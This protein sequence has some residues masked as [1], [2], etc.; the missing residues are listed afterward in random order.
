MHHQNKLV[1]F[2]I[3]QHNALHLSRPL[4]EAPHMR[5]NASP[6]GHG[7]GDNIILHGDLTFS[8]VDVCT[9]RP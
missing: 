4:D 9:G 1:F 5:R 7:P 8:M 6:G 3:L 2:M